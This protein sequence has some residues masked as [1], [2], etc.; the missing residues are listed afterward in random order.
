MQSLGCETHAFDCTLQ[1]GARSVTGKKFQFHNWCIGDNQNVSIPE[2]HYV[3][4]DEANL[5][6]KTLTETM[7]EL[8]HTYIDLLKFDIE[9]FE[10][11]LF[12]TEIL[13]S[14]NPPEQLSFELHTQK[15]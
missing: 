7:R 15:A 5:K 12:Q 11:Q 10:W 9:G 14:K 13:P 8:G 3:K 6:F 2:S 4:T 1:P